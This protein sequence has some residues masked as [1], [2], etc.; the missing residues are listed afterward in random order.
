[1]KYR[2]ILFHVLSKRKGKR[3]EGF[4]GGMA[5]WESRLGSLRYSTGNAN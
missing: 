4:V 5:K 2:H 3:G 1:M